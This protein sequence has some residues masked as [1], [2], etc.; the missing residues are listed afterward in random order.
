MVHDRAP[1]DYIDADIN[2]VVITYMIAQLL[3]QD[4][5]ETYL[6]DLSSWFVEQGRD[7]VIVVGYSIRA[8]PQI[9][10]AVNPNLKFIYCLVVLGLSLRCS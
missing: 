10:N 8:S 6:S 5:V 2:G 3:I 9:I 4:C 1:Y 7:V